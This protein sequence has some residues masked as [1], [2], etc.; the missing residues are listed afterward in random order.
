MMPI[1]L[2]RTVKVMAPHGDDPRAWHFP[3]AC[4]P[5]VRR[6]TL[7][8]SVC[9]TCAFLPPPRVFGVSRSHA[10]LCRV[11]SH[12]SWHGLSLMRMPAACL[13]RLIAWLPSG[14]P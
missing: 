13:S 12:P 2:S 9:L 8:A 7:T 11:V 14:Q 3:G 4:H 6:D 1:A 10:V 5:F